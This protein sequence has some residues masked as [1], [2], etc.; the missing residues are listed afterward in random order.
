MHIL[1]G[2]QS[3]I[4]R[5]GNIDIDDYKPPFLHA[6]TVVKCMFFMVDIV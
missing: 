4:S 3:L 5:I 1:G 2:A 6:P